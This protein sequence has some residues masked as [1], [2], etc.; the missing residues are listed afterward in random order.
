M[1]YQV[2][3]CCSTVEFSIRIR[4]WAQSTAKVLYSCCCCRPSHL[5]QVGHSMAAAPPSA[6]YV[7]IHRPTDPASDF[8]YVHQAGNETPWKAAIAAGQEAKIITFHQQKGGVGKTT[9]SYAIVY[10]RARAGKRVL[11]IDADNQ[12]KG[13]QAALAKHVFHQYGDNW[14]SFFAV[15]QLNDTLL[16]TLR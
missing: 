2:T 11:W 13:L 9:C 1:T 7:R 8:H 10:G 16:T 4:K 14:D 3:V 6:D 5:A 12:C 15:T